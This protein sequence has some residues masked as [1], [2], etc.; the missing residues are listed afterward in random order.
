MRSMA[1]KSSAISLGDACGQLPRHHRLR[2]RWAC[3]D[4]HLYCSGG[5]DRH[6]ELSEKIPSPPRWLS[7]GE[8][9]R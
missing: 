1:H 9:Q 3:K 4:A 8:Y 5:D 2:Y 7:Y 6:F